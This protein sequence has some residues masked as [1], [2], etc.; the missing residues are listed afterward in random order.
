MPHSSCSVACLAAHR[1]VSPDIAGRS[2]RFQA[3]AREADRDVDVDG[4]S[5]KWVFRHSTFPFH[6]FSIDSVLVTPAPCSNESKRNSDK[7]GAEG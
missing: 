6:P 1:T 3:K 4:M 7:Q 2:A 5:L